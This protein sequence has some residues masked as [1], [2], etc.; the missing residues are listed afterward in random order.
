MLHE[1][2]RKGVG[3]VLKLDF[4][5]PYDQVNWSFL[6]QCLVTRGFSET[7]C[8]WVQKVVQDGPIAVKLN[9]IV[10]LYFQ[11]FKGAR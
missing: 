7:W 8:G 9:G 1:T 11:S 6:R 4:E 2:K 3:V 10:G 5:K